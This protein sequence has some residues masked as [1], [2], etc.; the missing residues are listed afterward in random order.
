MKKL[1]ETQTCEKCGLP[2]DKATM[3]YA[4]P[5]ALPGHLIRVCP[6]CGYKWREIPLDG[7][8]EQ[9]NGKVNDG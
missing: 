9:E 6:R 7:E 1:F 4:P 2:T 8:G 3:T 5:G